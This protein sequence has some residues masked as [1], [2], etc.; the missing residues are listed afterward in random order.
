MNINNIALVRA[1]NIIP[2]DG[3][4]KPISN[5]PYLV[6]NIGL[7][8]SFRMSGLLRERGIIPPLDPTKMFDEK[9]YD[10]MAALSS[11]ILKSYLPYVSDYNSMVLFSLNGLCPDDSEH[12]F[13]NNTFSN[14][15]CAIIEPL[16]KHINQVISLVPTDTAIKGNVHLSNE[17]IILI[18]ENTFNKLSEKQKSRLANLNLSIRTFHGSLKT[19]VFET[20]KNTDRFIPE[21][22]SLSASTG[23]ILPSDT[24]EKQKKLISIICETYRLSQKKYFDLITSTDTNASEYDQ[25]C[26]EYKN[27]L[28][29]QDYFMTLFLQKL[30]KLLKAPEDMINNISSQLYNKTYMLSVIKLIKD[31]GIENYKQFVNEYNKELEQQFINGTLITPSEVVNGMSMS[32]GE[33]KKI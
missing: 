33:N 16:I 22:L 13:G 28:T 26:D 19:A 1:T 2:F 6:K 24:S 20:L 9:Y 27:M 10:E 29:V 3:I 4:V 21:T 12:G 18:D 32:L 30:L 25:V 23:G 15:A 31:F 11:S 5:V 8:F 14:K 7:E 17:A